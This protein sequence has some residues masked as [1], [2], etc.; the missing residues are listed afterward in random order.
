MQRD[1]V[2]HA[3]RSQCLC[4]CNSRL[5]QPI[6]VVQSRFQTRYIKLRQHW[7]QH[8]VLRPY[9]SDQEKKGKRKN[10]LN[11]RDEHT[12]QQRLLQR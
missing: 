9:L 4:C 7:T 2:H 6:S 8:I 11:V 3:W 5:L 12:L 1:V 10:K